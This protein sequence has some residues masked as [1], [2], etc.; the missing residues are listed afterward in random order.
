MADKTV[1]RLS[2]TELAA[3]CSQIAMVLSAGISAAEGVALMLEDANENGEKQLLE[4]IGG[5]LDQ[6]GS[7]FEALK[8]TGAYPDYMLQMVHIGEDTGKLDEVMKSLAS[9][10]DREASIVR[11]IRSAVTYPL[12]MIVMMVCIIIVLVTKVMPVFQQVYRQFGSEMTGVSQMILNIGNILRHFSVVFIVL[13]ALLVAAGLYFGCTEKGRA[14]MR[15][16]FRHFKG[17]RAYLERLS[18]CRFASCMQLTLASGMPTEECLA[19]AD[20]L[21]DDKDMQ[22]RIRACRN[23]M[24]A[25]AEFSAA[26]TQAGIFSGVYA[27][28]ASIGARTGSTDEV[29]QEIAD[30]YQ[31]EIDQRLTG[32]ISALEPAIVIVLSL[33]V[34]LILLSVMLPLMGIMSGI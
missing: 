1:S 22:A 23:S 6:T 3:F 26:L 33:V 7:F 24:E 2:N 17:T 9:H 20:Q 13:L 10:Y 34:G 19:Y 25:G 32:I 30:R 27:R 5:T 16:V 18:S 4:R 11:S 21:I 12:I 28:L 14:K 29:M 31:D 15:R 8:E